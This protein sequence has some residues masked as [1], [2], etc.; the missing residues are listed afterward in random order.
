VGF[1]PPLQ[2]QDNIFF[3]LFQECDI[4]IFVNSN[5]TNAVFVVEI[6]E[7]S[8]GVGGGFFLAVPASFLISCTP[9]GKSFSCL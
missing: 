2:E 1:R 3:V 5:E 4:R 8:R 6:L 7:F 9:T